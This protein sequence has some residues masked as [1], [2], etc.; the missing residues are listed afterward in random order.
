L[1][2][3]PDWSSWFSEELVRKRAIQPLIGFGCQ[4]VVVTGTKKRFLGWIGGALKR[5]R[6][7]IPEQP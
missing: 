6:I 4:P 3:L 7:Q 1:P 2:V 5:R